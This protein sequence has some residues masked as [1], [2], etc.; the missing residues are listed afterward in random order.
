MS[1]KYF[2]V[3]I[4]AE[5]GMQADKI[6]ES[7]LK[8][9]LVAGGLLLNGPSRFWWRGKIVD[10]NYTNISTFTKSELKKAVIGDVRKTSVEEVP[11]IW[12]VEFE[13]NKELLNWIEESLR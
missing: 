3:F 6:L 11:M 1:S 13:G 4:S 2:Q 9:K 8:K 10:M 7:L 12:F 5:N